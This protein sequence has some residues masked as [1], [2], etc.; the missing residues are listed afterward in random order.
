MFSKV[1]GCLNRLH[2]RGYLRELGLDK[3]NTKYGLNRLHWRG[4]LREEGG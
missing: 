2:W 4:Y 3:L 1:T